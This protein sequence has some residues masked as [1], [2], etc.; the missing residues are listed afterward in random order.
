MMAAAA[1][2]IANFRFEMIAPR[3]EPPNGLG[4]QLRP[5]PPKVAGAPR[6][7]ARL[8][9]V[10]WGRVGRQLQPLV[11][12]RAQW[13]LDR[14]EVRLKSAVRGGYERGFVGAQLELSVKGHV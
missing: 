12:R 13:L 9:Q 6:F 2:A 3:F 1:H 5:T 7:E 4:V 14:L 11:R 8:Y 10:S